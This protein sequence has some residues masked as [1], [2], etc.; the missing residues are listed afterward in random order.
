MRPNTLRASLLASLVTRRLPASHPRTILLTFD[1]GP[2]PGVTEGVL[3][4]L[5]AHGARALF[6]VLGPRVAQAPDLAR[7]I[8]AGG[9]AL[10][11]HSHRHDMGAAP[12]P[13]G[14]LRDMGDCSAAIA[15][16]TGSPPR[17]FRA[18][19]GR[20]HPASLLGPRRH[21]MQH[22][23]WSLDSEDWRCTDPAA[24]ADVAAR[25]LDSVAGRDIVLLHD[26]STVVHA[27]LDHLLPGLV[28]RGFD[29]AGGLDA[30][31]GKGGGADA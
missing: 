2:M 15:A 17:F 9:H 18:P 31:D 6:C 25:V 12:A 1:D 23:L 24:A 27:L 13:W 10:G 30:L 8:V 16:A 28:A 4:R 3:E 7:A 20:L 29:L 26:Y 11:N 5:Q 21:G 22:V 14:Y 19:G